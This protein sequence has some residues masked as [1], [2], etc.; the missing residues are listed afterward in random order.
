MTQKVIAVFDFD[1]TLTTKD[2]LMPFLKFIVGKWRYFGGLIVC[3]PILMA[4]L[5]KLTP[6]W[7]AK[8][9]VLK[10][11]LKNLTV[12]ELDKLSKKFAHRVIPKL[13]RDE[14]MERVKWH[15]KQE[16]ELI[17]VSASLDNYLAAWGEKE[18]FQRVISTQL[19]ENEGLITGKIRGKNC[20]GQEKV[21]RLQAALGDLSQYCIY[22]YGDSD[23]DR[24]LLNIA[25]YPYYRK[26]NDIKDY[27][28]QT[29][30]TSLKWEK[31]LIWS[32]IGAVV[33]YLALVLWSGADKFWQ[34]LNLLPFWLIP[35]LLVV[36]FFGYCLRFIRWQWYLKTMGYSVP[37]KNSFQIFLASF[38]LTASPAKA[39]ESIK[40]LFLKRR[41]NI[42]IPPTLAGLFCERFTDALS[43]IFLICFSIFS[44]FEGQKWAIIILVL[45]QL[46]IIL[47]LQNPQLLTK[48]LLKPLQKISKLKKLVLKIEDL[49]NSASILL[50]PKILL[51]STLLAAVAWGLEGIALYWIFQ[52][53]GVDKITPYQAVLTHTGSGL[54]GALSMLPGGIGG[55]EALTI[56][57]SVLYGATQTT[58]TVATF[59]IRL[60]TLWFAVV[61]GIV[62]LLDLN[63]K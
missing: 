36:I 7:K 49:I 38:A 32:V 16:H 50:K 2:S 45:I 40:S 24:Q 52:N 37:I 13:I 28:G 42:P 51:G 22:A 19:E 25:T 18:G 29:P 34:A 33:L 9:F 63:K 53:L 8:E 43:V 62:A 61:I 4:Y 47:A 17:I 5:L 41:Y 59:L 11:F 55:T 12:E 15:R 14:A 26:F 27:H 6:N 46:A 1:N 44:L 58:A 39:G 21:N 35:S 3:S 20:Y 30:P 56:S 10:Y 23:G 31:G 60:L 54:I 57:L 48:Y